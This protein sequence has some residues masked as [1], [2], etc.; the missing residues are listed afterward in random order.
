MNYNRLRELF[1]KKISNKQEFFASI[2][3]S[4]SGFYAMLKDETLKVKV[5][6]AIS[7]AMNVSPAFWWQEEIRGE[8]DTKLGYIPKKVYDELMKMWKE[9]RERCSKIEEQLEFMRGLIDES[10]RKNAC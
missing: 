10:K 1:R 4:S 9:D 8:E 2:G 5:L 6:E 3:M 7:D